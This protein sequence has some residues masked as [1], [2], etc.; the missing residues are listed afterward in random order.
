MT[1]WTLLRSR[2]RCLGERV[3]D[4]VAG[5]LPEHERRRWDRHLVSC[6]Y[7]R[8]EVEVERRVRTTLRGSDPALPGDL[9]AMLLAVAGAG[10]APEGPRPVDAP[11]A[12]PPAAR[13]SRP[14]RPSWPRRLAALPVLPPEAPACHRS[15]LRAAVL[16]GLAAGATVA[17][18]WSLAAGATPPATGGGLR[19]GDE[20]SPAVERSGG[21]PG[22]PARARGV[23]GT[24]TLLSGVRPT[25]P[26]RG[27]VGHLV[28]RLVGPGAARRGGSPAESTP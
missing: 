4:Y 18:A 28:D 1:R 25:P 6:G 12:A 16:A 23:V 27:D 26:A 17:A 2:P 24:A 21:T 13:T 9:R 10:A 20:V 11:M 5:T 19:S 15:A 22:A 7:C 3:A 14:A 8:H